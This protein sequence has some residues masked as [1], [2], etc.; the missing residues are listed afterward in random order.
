MA[1]E[2]TITFVPHDCKAITKD[3]REIPRAWAGPVMHEQ[4]DGPEAAPGLTWAEAGDL[5]IVSNRGPWASILENTSCPQHMDPLI[6][7]LTW[8]LEN[9]LEPFPPWDR[10]CRD[11]STIPSCGHLPA[12]LSSAPLSPAHSLQPCRPLR[13][14]S[15]CLHRLDL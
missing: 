13:P 10:P 12:P 1:T 7:V 2:F 6:F 14:S 15:R 9:L 4:A 8:L 5:H 3:G 11:H